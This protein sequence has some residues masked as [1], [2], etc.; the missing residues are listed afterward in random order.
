MEEYK[1]TVNPATYL[2]YGPG[3]A[4]KAQII[5]D[6]LEEKGLADEL[7]YIFSTNREN[8]LDLTITQT[9]FD[10]FKE[11]RVSHILNLIKDTGKSGYVIL[12][13]LEN[14]DFLNSEAF[15]EMI[16]RGADSNVTIFITQG[17]WKC[18]EI[19]SLNPKIRDYVEAFFILPGI[20]YAEATK[21]FSKWLDQ[22]YDIELEYIEKDH[23]LVFSHC[24]FFTKPMPSAFMA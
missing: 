5:K 17:T 13:D 19:L 8:W 7:G 14:N 20:S 22:Y 2:I 1:V 23:M 6:I 9:I 21:V 11:N 3:F 12:H 10:D 4:N 24:G 18:G 15:R 16:L